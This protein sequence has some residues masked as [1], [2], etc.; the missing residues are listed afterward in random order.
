MI[1]DLSSHIARHQI[2]RSKNAFVPLSEGGKLVLVSKGLSTTLSMQGIL[3]RDIVRLSGGT[4]YRW[5]SDISG[6][7]Q[8]GKLY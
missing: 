7:F 4:T 1:L 3:G 6:S 8:S 2:A 5:V